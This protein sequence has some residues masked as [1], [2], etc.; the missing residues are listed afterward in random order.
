MPRKLSEE[1]V[2]KEIDIIQNGRI[3]IIGEYKNNTTSVM[4]RCINC[5]IEWMAAP[6]MLRNRPVGIGCKHHINFTE[7]QIKQRILNVTKGKISMIGR[8]KGA[9]SKAKMRCNKCQYEWFTEPYV[10]YT[11]HDCP[12]CANRQQYTTEEMANK[13]HELTNGEYELIGS[14]TGSHKKMSIHHMDSTCDRVFKMSYHAFSSGQR[15]PYE[16]RERFGEAVKKTKQDYLR[17]LQANCQGEYSLIG[18]YKNASTQAWF[19]HEKC[20]TVFFALPTQVAHHATGCPF[21]NASKGEMAVRKYLEIHEYVF[22]EQY[23]IDACRNDRTLP[24]DFAVFNS[25]GLTCLIE[26]QGVQHYQPKFG[27]KNFEDGKKRDQIKFN[28]CK[29]HQIKLIRIPYKRW[30]I[31]NQLQAQVFSYLDKNLTR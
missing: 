3:K 26:Y 11:G 18:E 27:Q 1:E 6:K 16:R 10:I 8:Y 24:F 30:T 25:N 28:Y 4:V 5:G 23:K 9:K 29:K 21:C 17:E 7:T 13:I 19:R 15:C 14:Y 12:R 2:Q 20:G 22:T 31:Y